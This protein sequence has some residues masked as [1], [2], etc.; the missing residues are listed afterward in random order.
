MSDIGKMLVHMAINH[1]K[2]VQGINFLEMGNCQ[3]THLKIKYHLVLLMC[4]EVKEGY[5]N[6]FKK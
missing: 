2:L 5:N 6:S 3:R 1:Q 4:L